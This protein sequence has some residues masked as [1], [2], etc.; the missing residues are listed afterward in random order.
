MPLSVRL[1]LSVCL[2]VCLCLSV[3]PSLSVGVSVSFSIC[4]SVWLSICRSLS[5]SLSIFIFFARGLDEKKYC[6]YSIT[7]VNKT[8]F[9]RSFVL[10]LS[11]CLSLSG[12]SHTFPTKGVDNKHVIVTGL[13]RMQYF[14]KSLYMLMSDPFYDVVAQLSGQHKQLGLG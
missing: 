8:K 6:T 9:V 11:V 3:C 10:C 2:S 12:R 13:L 5:L 1:C 4:L 14:T 7:I